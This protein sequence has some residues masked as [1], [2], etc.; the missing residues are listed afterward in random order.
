MNAR[1]ARFACVLLVTALGAAPPCAAQA[2]G[3]HDATA[4]EREIHSGD[5]RIADW[6]GRIDRPAPSGHREIAGTCIARG[7]DACH[8]AI[9]VLRD[10]QSGTHAVIA[11]RQL[12]ALDDSRPGGARPLSLVTDALEVQ[13]LDA[14]GNEISV[15]LCEQ[16]GQSAPRIVAVIDRDLDSEWYVR[17]ERLWRLDDAGRL[18]PLPARGV[19]C[20]NEGYGYDG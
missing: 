5:A 14:Q 13:A 4:G 9:S 17:F 18:Q 12:R 7:E 6:I 16:G 3:S 8:E 1:R 10:E 19:R 2:T 15:G 11:T 20:L